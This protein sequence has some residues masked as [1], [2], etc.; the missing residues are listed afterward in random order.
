MLTAI[1]SALTQVITWV[2]SVISALTDAQGALA[3]LL[4][5]FAV[6]IACSVLFFGIKAIRKVAWGA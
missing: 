5:I 1:T 4:P 6:G 3:E 2:G